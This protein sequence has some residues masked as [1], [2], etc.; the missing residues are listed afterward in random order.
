MCVILVLLCIIIA[1][2]HLCIW[3]AALCL[4]SYHRSRMNRKQLTT[5]SQL[6]SDNF[7][8]RPHPESYTNHHW[9][10]VVMKTAGETSRFFLS[11]PGRTLQDFHQFLSENRQF[12]SCEISLADPEVPLLPIVFFFKSCSFL[13]ILWGKNPILSKIWAQAPPPLRSKLCWAPSD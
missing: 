4:S 10:H 11:P 1:C 9:T 7:R 13:A 6:R 12:S 3:F 5:C 8:N 2:E